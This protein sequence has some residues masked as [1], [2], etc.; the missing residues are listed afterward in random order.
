MMNMPEAAAELMAGAAEAIEC[1][2]GFESKLYNLICG[3]RCTHF[4][5]FNSS[6]HN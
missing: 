4:E 5:W 3:C 6:T 2:W 1:M